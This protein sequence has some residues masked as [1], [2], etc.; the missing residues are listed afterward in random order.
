MET[1]K[2]PQRN[3]KISITFASARRRRDQI[4]VRIRKKQKQNNLWKR[5]MQNE[6]QLKPQ[7][8]ASAI[9]SK[10]LLPMH[11]TKSERRSKKSENPYA[12]Y[13]TNENDTGSYSTRIDQIPRLV[14]LLAD[15]TSLQGQILALKELRKML[16]LGQT[17][18]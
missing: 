1:S 10:N 11:A 4:S 18:E 13:N 16:S 12:L 17:T 8:Q 6:N 14:A 5:R 15:Q 7:K 3:L 2:P 9:S